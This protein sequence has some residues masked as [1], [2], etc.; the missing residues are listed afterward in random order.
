MSGLVSIKISVV[1][2]YRIFGFY[3]IYGG[4]S[5]ILSVSLRFHSRYSFLLCAYLFGF[6]TLACYLLKGVCFW[7][8]PPFRHLIFPALVGLCLGFGFFSPQGVAGMD[9]VECVVFC[10]LGVHFGSTILS[11]WPFLFLG[12]ACAFLAVHSLQLVY[13]PLENFRLLREC[14]LGS[15]CVPPNVREFHTC[16]SMCLHTFLRFFVLF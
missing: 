9:V 3:T 6:Y 1:L 11:P 15:C 13:C 16:C 4:W 10:F 2:S 8:I 14:V 12:H 5:D 7:D